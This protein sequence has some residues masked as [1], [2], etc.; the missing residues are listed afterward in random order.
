MSG[1]QVDSLRE[2]PQNSEEVLMPRLTDELKPGMAVYDDTH[3]WDEDE[4]EDDDDDD[5]DDG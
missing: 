1:L 5:D 2:L 4:D 3:L